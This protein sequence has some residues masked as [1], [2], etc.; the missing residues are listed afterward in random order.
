[1]LLDEADDI[2][3]NSAEPRNTHFQ[4]CDHDAKNLPEKSGPG[5]TQRD[6]A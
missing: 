3:A 5:M 2:G 6:H 4:G 1:L